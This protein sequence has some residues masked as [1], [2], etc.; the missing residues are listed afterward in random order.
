MAKYNVYNLLD[1]SMGEI[2]VEAKNIFIAMCKCK[3]LKNLRDD[4][5]INI[6]STDYATINT[7][8]GTKVYLVLKEEQ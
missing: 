7:P 4:A 2:T 5:N 8:N 1:Y 3:V 6:V